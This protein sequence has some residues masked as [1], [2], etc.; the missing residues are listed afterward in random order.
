MVQVDDV[1]QVQVVDLRAGDACDGIAPGFRTGRDFIVC[2]VDSE[3]AVGRNEVRGRI[4][5][6]DNLSVADLE[7]IHAGGKSP[8]RRI[9]ACA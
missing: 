2:R 3:K 1:R 9:K 4:L 7:N 5:R 8:K 6:Q